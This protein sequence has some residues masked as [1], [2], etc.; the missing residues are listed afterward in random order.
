MD[1]DGGAFTPSPSRI[2]ASWPAGTFVENIAVDAAGDLFVTVHNANKIVK[3][4]PSTGAIAGFA[5]FPVPVAGVVFDAAGTLWVSGGTPGTAPGVIFQVSPAG[6]VSHWCDV[7]EA[8][9]LNGMTLHPDGRHALVA[10]SLLG[11][12][13]EVDLHTPSVSVWLQDTMIAPRQMG[14]TPGANGV[15]ITDGYVYVTVTE[16]DM[17]VRAPLDAAGRPG[18]IE[19]VAE[20]LRGDDF[21]VGADGA[22]YVATHPAH[23]LVRLEKDGSRTTLAGAEAGLAGATAVAFGRMAADADAVYVTTSGALFYPI[24]GVVQEARIVRVEVK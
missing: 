14:Q 19:I 23:S 9:F 15:K 5:N 11:Q 21:A 8:I 7:P 1:H 22:F 24:D 2:V 20:R 10:E 17:M 18:A 3:V 12:I 16:R 6:V 4:T 13:L